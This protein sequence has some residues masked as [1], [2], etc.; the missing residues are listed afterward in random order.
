MSA[1]PE[2]VVRRLLGDQWQRLSSQE[3][4]IVTRIARRVRNPEQ[5][6]HDR[7]TVGERASDAIAAFGGSWPFILLF[8]TVLLTWTL[9]NTKLLGPLRTFDPY[10]FIFLNLLLSMLAAIQAPIIM[11]SQNR[12]AERDRLAAEVDHEV[13]VRAELAVRDID[14]RLRHLE[15]HMDAMAQNSFPPTST[16]GERLG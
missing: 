2:R 10:P 16:A 1:D 9:L 15:S 5:E 3:R 7:R 8:L 13:N 6:F 12:A 4:E 14:R 11:M